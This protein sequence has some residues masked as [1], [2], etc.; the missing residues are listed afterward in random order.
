MGKIYGAAKQVLVWLGPAADDSD[1]V[2]KLW[3]EIGRKPRHLGIEGYWTKERVD[4]LR[5]I[6]Q[7]RAHR[8]A[9]RDEPL[10]RPDCELCL[11]FRPLLKAMV[12]WNRR[13]WFRRVWLLQEFSLPK[14]VPL[15]VCGTKCM[16][17][18]L[19]SAAMAIYYCSASQLLDEPWGSESRGD[20]KN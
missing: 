16:A 3:Q 5:P 6:Y 9:R 10:S 14:Q 2:M 1:K 15:Y 13:P 7:G 19:I 8:P 18:S 12:T 11:P 17:A 4:L 20:V